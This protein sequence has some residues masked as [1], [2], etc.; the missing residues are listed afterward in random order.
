MKK[1]L[2]AIKPYLRW[3]ILGGTLFFVL[4]AFKDN[5]Q[6]VAAIKIEPRGWLLLAIA[7]IITLLAHIWSG[8][9]W[10]GLLKAFRQPVGRGWAL[11]VYLITN[12]AKYLPGNVGHFYGRIS[13]VYQAGGSL[14]SAS[15]SVLLE[16]L[17]MGAAAFLI[18]LLA[19]SIGL[20]KTSFSPWTWQI[21]IVLLLIVLLGIHP[22]ILNPSLQFLSRL[23]NKEK[24]STV[25]I[26]Q[27]PLVYLL[28]EV[29]FLLLRGSGF[30]LTW[31]ALIP[32]D[33][34]QIPTLFSVF[35]FAWLM[36]LI[37]PGAPGGIGVFEAT[38]IAL[39]SGQHFPSGIVLSTIAL[40][41]II[42]ILAEAIAAGLAWLM[43]K[44]TSID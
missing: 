20:I 16:P 25:T 13:A 38:A 37:V 42:S 3:V 17:L 6:N 7:L 35:S 31:I 30:L 41:R 28:G 19:Y 12:L 4:K 10:T 8:L 14:G 40:F 33:L 5:W 21:N 2:L 15:L 18:T 29:G 11:Q 23:K 32:L 34:S 9:V 43:K 24:G 22:K 36:G 1:F 26:E 39:L 44:K 27:Y